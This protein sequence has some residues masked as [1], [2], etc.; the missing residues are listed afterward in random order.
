MLET[1]I[2]V[3]KRVVTEDL[4]GDLTLYVMDVDHFIITSKTIPILEEESLLKRRVKAEVQGDK[5]AFIL[6]PK[7]YRFYHLDENDY[8][9]M[10]S[11]KDPNILIVTV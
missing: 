11:D 6:P 9:I 2:E 1:R 8:T 3:D 4:S 10:V 7:V 5:Y